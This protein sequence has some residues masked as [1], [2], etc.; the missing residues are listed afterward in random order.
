M[1]NVGRG[2]GALLVR[3]GVV[4]AVVAVGWWSA[5]SHAPKSGGAN[6]L[7]PESRA[8]IGDGVKRGGDARAGAAS[9]EGASILGRDILL[10]SSPAPRRGMLDLSRLP[11]VG[12]GARV[13][14]PHT[15]MDGAGALQAR[16]DATAHHPEQ[17][18]WLRPH[19]QSLA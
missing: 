14:R 4:L 7:F 10:S 2:G 12:L 15:R 18:Y 19:A 6:P 17:L 5:T 9:R 1:R 13:A 11:P 16:G 8:A 3:T